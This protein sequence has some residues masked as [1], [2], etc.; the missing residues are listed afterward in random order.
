VIDEDSLA[1][2]VNTCFQEESRQGVTQSTGYNTGFLANDNS[3]FHSVKSGDRGVH[4]SPHFML[5]PPGEGPVLELGSG[6]GFLGDFISDLITSDIFQIAGID[7][8]LDGQSLPFKE[9]SLRGIVM[10]DVLHH[11]P[12]V[13]SFF[14]KSVRCIEP[15]GVI[16]MVEPWNTRWS[17]LIYRYLHHEPYHPETKKWDFAEGGPLS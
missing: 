16:V 11:I 17:A 5:L 9:G 8:M 14:D 2:G 6:S 3:F 13:K 10:V 15:G 12:V 7:V 1:G 4:I